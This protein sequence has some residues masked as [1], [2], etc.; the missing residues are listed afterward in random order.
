MP[1]HKK[2]LS[3]FILMTF[4]LVG[5]AQENRN[6]CFGY[7]A[8]IDFTNLSN[9]VPFESL[10]NN[11]EANASI[12]DSNG[13]LLFYLA[14]AGPDFYGPYNILDA[15]HNLI[16]NGDSIW[17][18]T[19]ST[20]GIIILPTTDNHYF[21]FYISALLENQFICP[22]LVYSCD[23]LFYSVVAQSSTGEL[24]VIEKNK[25]LSSE[26]FSERIAATR[27][28]NGNYWWIVT[29]E[30]K[31][32]D[33][34]D[35]FFTFLLSDNNISE[36]Y[37]QNISTPVCTLGWYGE[38]KFSPNGEQLALAT[39]TYINNEDYGILELLKFDRC[40]GFLYG[41]QTLE[42]SL[43]YHPYG[44]EFSRD[45]NILYVSEGEERKDFR[46]FQYDL[47]NN[48]RRIIYSENIP[49]LSRGQLELGPN[50]KI[51][52][53]SAYDY[54]GGGTFNQ[55]T[56][57]LSVINEPDS[58][59]SKCDFKSYNFYLGD[60]S[61]TFLG[62]PN[63][64]NYNLD[65]LSIYQADAGINTVICEEDTTVKGVILGV[66]T[67]SSVTYSWDPTDSLNDADTS[68]PF[69][70]PSQTT[71]YVVTVTDTSIKNSCQ[72]REDTVWV[73]VKNCSVGINNPSSIINS[74]TISPNPAH[75]Q[76]HITLINS[77]LFFKSLQFFTLEGRELFSEPNLH[78]S[79]Y[80]LPT[81]QYPPGLYLLRITL[82]N[83]QSVVK[84]VVLE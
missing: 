30:F 6:W 82:T 83:G 66:P 58:V 25:L 18:N 46:I 52:V 11:I 33:C 8:G 41:K 53:T 42:N 14:D 62:L 5:F 63:M 29:R 39:S 67:V 28:A 40:S 23:Y 48:F 70:Y 47:R 34:S 61:T 65:P 7:G 59:G 31:K 10:C 51:Y 49:D 22:P 38:M 55:Y 54:A 19:S 15:N 12:S 78:A 9:P 68:Q 45:G 21:L 79:H 60:S 84:K 4:F 50:N 73:V 72:S 13:N 56:V 74:I 77:S 44:I 69:A 37:V 2:K 64:P 36:P 57:H 3:L 26:G 43:T 76:L 20:N 27:H 80:S 1:L 35:R 24:E 32:L 71:M 75:T 17:A 81:S 16:N